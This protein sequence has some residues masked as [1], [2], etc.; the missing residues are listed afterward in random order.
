MRKTKIY[1]VFAIFA[2]TL[3]LMTTSLAGP[4]RE[5]IQMDAEENLENAVDELA[6]KLKRDRVAGS[7][8]DSLTKDPEIAS[9]IES[10]RQTE[11]EAEKAAITVEIVVALEDKTEIQQLQEIIQSKYA[12]EQEYIEQSTQLVLAE[13]FNDG[14][15]Y[16]PGQS[17]GERHPGVYGAIPFD[18]FLYYVKSTSDDTDGDGIIDFWDDDMDGDGILDCVELLT[19]TNPGSADTD[20]D[21][22]DDGTEAALGTDPND[23]DDTPTD[24]EVEE[25]EA[26]NEDI[27]GNILADN[28]YSQ[29]E[30]DEILAELDLE[31]GE[32]DWQLIGIV[33]LA[34][35]GGLAAVV[36]LLSLAVSGLAGALAVTA[37]FLQTVSVFLALIG[38]SALVMATIDLWIDY[39]KDLKGDDSDTP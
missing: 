9:L 10:Y 23:P 16:L 29:E 35:T 31:D 6:E 24:E 18:T 12:R 37:E 27:I 30:I 17:P 1:V 36:F 11:G 20:G 21:G 3:M 34:I 7:L 4:I 8:I 26:T 32:I 15:V 39:L 13:N 5:R 14:Q 25:N 28:G 2:A 22:V 38:V 19:G 33:I